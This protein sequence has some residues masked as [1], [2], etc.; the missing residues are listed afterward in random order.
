MDSLV[1]FGF[2]VWSSS[3]ILGEFGSGGFRVY[4]V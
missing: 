3:G 2:R 1:G 4:G